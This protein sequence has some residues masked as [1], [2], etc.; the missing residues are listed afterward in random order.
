MQ[1]GMVWQRTGQRS[2]CEEQW[3]GEQMWCP[4]TELLGLG[5]CGESGVTAQ[6]IHFLLTASSCSR[7]V[8]ARPVPAALLPVPQLHPGLL[9]C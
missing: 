6:P 4:D 5:L 3:S 7:F 8:P 1:G 9:P 2:G